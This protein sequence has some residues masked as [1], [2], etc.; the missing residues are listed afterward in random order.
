[1][2][3]P[4]RGGGEKEGGGGGLLCNFEAFLGLAPQ[5]STLY[6]YYIYIYSINLCLA[7]S[8][9]KMFQT[10]LMVAYVHIEYSTYQ[11]SEES[12]G[13]GGIHPPPGPCGTE[14]SVVLRGLDREIGKEKEI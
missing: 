1:M 14:K 9:L 3:R 10:N 12:K 6:I 13:G 7:P 8:K 11:F 2:A 5:S 4:F